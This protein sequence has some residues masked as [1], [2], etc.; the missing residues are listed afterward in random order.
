ML[1]AAEMRTPVAFRLIAQTA[2]GVVSCE[3][4]YPDAIGIGQQLCVRDAVYRK[5]LSEIE[6][7]EVNVSALL[8]RLGG[9]VLRSAKEKMKLPVFGPLFAQKRESGHLRRIA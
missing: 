4:H 5:H 3:C 6:E 1:A 9:V 2:V 7:G 8:A